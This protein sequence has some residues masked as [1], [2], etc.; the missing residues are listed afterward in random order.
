MNN[1]RTRIFFFAFLEDPAGVGA[2]IKMKALDFGSDR[3]KIGSGSSTL[4]FLSPDRGGGRP[5]CTR[6][7]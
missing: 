1:T 7:C 5:Q 4:I 6:H 3:L 2:S